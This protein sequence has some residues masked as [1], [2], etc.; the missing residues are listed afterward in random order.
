MP[1]GD[2]EMMG[3]GEGLWT[4]SAW[5]SACQLGSLNL[6]WHQ[7]L[8]DSWSELRLHVQRFGSNGCGEDCAFLTSCQAM[9]TPP[10]VLTTL[11]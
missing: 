11:E 8:L 3:P 1:A 5:K 10:S 2:L 6:S 9:L 4:S 7:N